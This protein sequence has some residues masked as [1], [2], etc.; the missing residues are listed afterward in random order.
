MPSTTVSVAVAACPNFFPFRMCSA[1]LVLRP[2][3][4]ANV[5]PFLVHLPQR[6]HLPKT[7]HLR[8]D[9]VD[10]VVHFLFR[11]EAPQTE[12]QRRVCEV[13]LGTNG[14]QHV[15]WFERCRCACRARGEGHV[16]ECHQQTLTLHKGKRQIDATGVSIHTVSVEDHF[17]QTVG[18]SRDQSIRQVL[19]VRRIA[20]HVVLGNGTGLA[21]S[22]TQRCGQGPATHATLLPA[23]RDERLE[24]DA[25]AASHVQRTHALGAVNLVTR[26]GHEINV[27]VIDIDRNLADGLGGV[28][29][30]ERLVLA[31]QGANLCNGLRRPNLIVDRHHRD[32]CSLWSNGCIQFLKIDQTR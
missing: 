25:R 13:L 10:R 18:D 4:L 16:L 21:Q 5:N 28:R 6:A 15:R 17:F 24:A 26:D 12:P 27:H 31:A 19:N 30:E 3:D 23:A 7:R 8:N 32:N 11:R 9:I 14:T 1:C 29:V 22:D 20:L 2:L